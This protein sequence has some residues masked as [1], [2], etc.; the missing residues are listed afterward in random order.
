MSNVVVRNSE[1]FTSTRLRRLRCGMPAP[2]VDVRAVGD[3]LDMLDGLMP[4]H[5]RTQP[6]HRAA[7]VPTAGLGGSEPENHIV[8]D[9]RR[10]GLK[11]AQRLGP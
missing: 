11:P 1:V 7:P 5:E 6:R 3:A 10:C 2:G 9:R 4:E 8:D